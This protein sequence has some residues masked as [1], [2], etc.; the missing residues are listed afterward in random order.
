MDPGLLELSESNSAN[1]DPATAFGVGVGILQV[2]Q[3]L[4]QSIISIR[5][6][7][8]E[9][10][11]V[12]RGM[13]GL[14]DE[15]DAMGTA[16]TTIKDEI[17]YRS[18][19]QNMAAWWSPDGLANLLGNATKTMTGVE[20]I[21]K[22]VTLAQSGSGGRRRRLPRLREYCRMNGKEITTLKLRMSIYIVSLQTP[23]SVLLR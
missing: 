16:L 6:H 18:L 7:M 15:L 17:E 9:I 23:T 8:Q 21:M 20:F 19:L 1:T 3:T 12:E 13:A 11:N 22:D 2:V 10:H 5:N 14:N 4:S